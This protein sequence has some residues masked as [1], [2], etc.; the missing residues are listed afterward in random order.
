MLKKKHPSSPYMLVWYAANISSISFLFS[1]PHILLFRR[2]LPP[3]QSWGT[4][5][6]ILEVY[7]KRFSLEDK[8]EN[9]VPLLRTHIGVYHQLFLHFFYKS[10]LW[11]WCENLSGNAPQRDVVSWLNHMMPLDNWLQLNCCDWSPFRRHRRHA[12]LGLNRWN[13]LFFI[14]LNHIAFWM[15]KPYFK[16]CR[17]GHLSVKWN[18][19][20]R[21][22]PYCSICANVSCH[23]PFP[24]SCYLCT[25][26]VICLVWFNCWSLTLCG[27]MLRCNGRQK[28]LIC[29]Y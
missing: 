21:W 15:N 25:F 13:G 19:W 8:N 26:N 1:E 16:L 20:G 27:Q 3:N 5:T 2:K 24:A 12:E 11:C 29:E 4:S 14:F 22:S 17:L 23:W 9:A 28:H 18:T 6:D 10:S 7:L